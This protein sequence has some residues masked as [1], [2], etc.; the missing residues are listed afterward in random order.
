MNIIE[1]LK[2]NKEDI[3]TKFK[4]SFVS[5]VT[6]PTKVDLVLTFSRNKTYSLVL[7]LNSLF[8]F[9]KCYEYKNNFSL[10][11]PFLN[12]IKFRLLNSYLESVEILNDDNIISL[13]FIK[14]NDTYDRSYFSL[15]FEIFKAN[16]NL[17]FV[18]E[19]KIIDAF[20]FR[21]LDSK[22]PI[23]NGITYL[24][25]A[26][27]LVSKEFKEES[28][29]NNYLNNL[30]KSYL[31]EKYG[32]IL[33]SLR[34]K[35]KSLNIKLEKLNHEKSLDLEHL[36]YKD[37]GDYILSNL[38]KIS[39]GDKAFKY[40]DEEI[41]LKENYTPIENSQY[42]YKQYKKAKTSLNL[43]DQY[44]S[45][46][47]EEINYLTSILE[48]SFSYNE[49]DYI[50]LIDELESTNLIKIKVK[51]PQ[52]KQKK[53]AE[54]YYFYKNGIKIGFGKNAKQNN[55]LTFKHAKNNY[56]F[57]HIKDGSG[58]HIVIFDENPSNEIIEC[59]CELALFLSK[60]NDG[61]VYFTK[62]KNVKKTSTLGLVNLLKYETYHISKIKNNFDLIFKDINRF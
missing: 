49:E 31:K 60:Q 15:I 26:K 12:K 40:F 2:I 19:N 14:V 3:E 24:F 57:L 21:G 10:P 38:D 34:R 32:S 23:L 62:I 6:M 50:D 58:A 43:I 55:N 22:H 46:T 37:Y 13:N 45:S 18:S 16:A 11:N 27:S 1:Y 7:S 51:K 54:P 29:I 52:I 5:K 8:P 59:A 17:I 25:P 36:V 9:I 61:D 39:K 48:M 30:E 41:K 28:L 56:Y 44:I 35:I 53:S 47:N 42:F 4:N 33:I 20:R